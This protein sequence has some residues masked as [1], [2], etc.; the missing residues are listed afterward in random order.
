MYALAL[1]LGIYAYSIFFLGI[2]GILYKNVVI[3][4]SI[5][6]I[7]IFIF[8]RR[9]VLLSWIKKY[10]FKKIVNALKS[11]NSK[12]QLL[13]Y[14]VLLIQLFINFFG[15]L[16]PELAFDAL[17]YHLTLP[18][19]YLLNHSIYHIPGGLLYYSDMPKLGEMLFIGALSFG[20]ENYAKFLQ[21]MF[22]I[23][24]AII[25]YRFTR[26]FYSKEISL[27]ATV[28]FYS[29]I[30]VAWE[31]TAA[32]V[33]LIRTFFEILALW[34]FVKWKKA[35]QTK[36]FILSAL[37]TGFA[38]TSKY[39]AFGSLFI[40]LLFILYPF[41]IKYL[42]KRIS[43]T[44]SY[45][46]ISVCIPLPWLIFA[47]IH[48]GN[49][50]Y[51]FF[52]TLYKITPEP[53]SLNQMFTDI[54][55]LFLKSPDPISP[56][57]IMLLPLIIFFFTKIK[58]EIKILVMYSALSVIIWYFTPRTGGGR[59]ILPYLP[60]MSIVCASVID[61]TL[62]QQKKQFSFLSNYLILFVIIISMTTISYRFLAE[63]KYIPVIL[64]KESKD[65]FL[66][67]NL[68]VAYGDFYDYKN[69]IKNKVDPSKIIL[70]YGFHNLYYVDFP[71]ID[72][73]W[74]KKG[75]EFTYI[76]TQNTQ[77]P[78]KYKDWQ[79]I[80]SNDKTKVKLYENK[81]SKTNRF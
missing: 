72:S 9:K 55:N 29:N 32:Y 28:I 76:A 26:E 37:M 3:I 64:G 48:T 2:I 69:E 21:F 58:N 12:M 34:S 79:M 10:N 54:W 43:Y 74:A 15:V 67:N 57:Y 68:N 45:F 1:F 5:F 31:S 6:S 65:T 11:E 7:S 8:N 23:L 25:I 46:L 20:N 39:L 63:M 18:K 24:T 78:A 49:L 80:Y 61:V 59:F 60:A 41:K 14:V 17:W 70:L 40:F 71:F 36:W 16:S 47:H 4:F 81:K 75:T 73:S 22:S 13:L 42:K 38:I 44:L 56:F 27:I 52:S 53:F 66:I 30:A 35:K 19:L 62:H 33:D 51:P 77:L 50:F